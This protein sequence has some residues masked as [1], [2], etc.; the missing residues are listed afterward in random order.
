[1]TP[2]FRY[3][4]LTANDYQEENMQEEKGNQYDDNIFHQ[5]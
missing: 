4:I 5:L 2:T 1:M 3:G